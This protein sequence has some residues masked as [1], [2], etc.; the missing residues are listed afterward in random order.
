MCAKPQVWNS[1]A[2][3]WVRQPW[4]SGKLPLLPTFGLRYRF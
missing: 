2:A 1:G 4:R 3:M